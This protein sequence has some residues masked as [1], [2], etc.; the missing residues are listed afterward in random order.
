MSFVA[1]DNAYSTLA[2]G[3]NDSVTTINVATGHG[4]RFA[5]GA[6]HSYVTLENAGGDIETCKITGQTGD[7]L[8]VVRGTPARSWLAGDVIECRPC[9]A[10]LVDILAEADANT[11]LVAD[12]VAAHLTDTADAHDASAISYAGGTGMSATDVEAALDELATEKANLAS[13][14]FT[15]TPAAPTAAAGTATTQLATTEFVDRLRDVPANAKTGA[16]TLALTDRGTSIDTTAG[17]TVPPNAT[18]A[19]P[20]GS[21]VTIT[22]TSASAITITQDTGVTLRYAG[23]ATT[24]NRTLAGYG[25]ATARKIATD[26][27]IIA[28]PGLT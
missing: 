8:T 23:T 26:A 12:A 27:W 6:N 7:A 5:V 10:A 21:V 13:P 16:Y 17:V 24:G 11:A 25:V 4:V 2:S 19:F 3:I 14:T 9:S 1:L 20:V 15:D 28:G 22:N 18:V